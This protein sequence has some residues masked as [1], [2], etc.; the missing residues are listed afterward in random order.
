M[1]RKRGRNIRMQTFRDLAPLATMYTFK[2]TLIKT[3]VPVRKLSYSSQGGIRA[4]EVS[5][6]LRWISFACLCAKMDPP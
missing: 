5:V 6:M 3:T 1:S 4:P 2:E